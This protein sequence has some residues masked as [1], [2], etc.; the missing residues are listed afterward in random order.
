[1]NPYLLPAIQSG[2]RVLARLIQLIPETQWDTALDPERFTLREVLAH[3]ADWEPIL[4]GR[5]Q[6]AAASPGSDF[7]GYDEGQ[8]AIDNNYAGSN[9]LEMLALWTRERRITAEYLRTLPRSLFTNAIHNPELGSRTVD[10]QANMLLGH[11]LYHIEQLA[12]YLG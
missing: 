10:D 1:M 6:L 8:M 9:P 3:L 11:D 4:R 7:E 12:A 5:I 2:P